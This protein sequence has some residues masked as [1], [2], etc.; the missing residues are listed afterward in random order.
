MTLPP[1]IGA[2][3]EFE[4]QLSQFPVRTYGPGQHLFFEDLATMLWALVSHHYLVSNF[5][6]VNLVG[7]R[8]E[9]H[10]RNL[11]A[12]ISNMTYRVELEADCTGNAVTFLT[13][14]VIVSIALGH[15]PQY[16]RIWDVPR[17]TVGNG[18]AIRSSVFPPLLRRLVG[19]SFVSFFEVAKGIANSKYGPNPYAWPDAL[20]FARIIRNSVAHGF[21][22]H[23][24]N[25]NA[26]PVTWKKWTYGPNDNGT[27]S[28]LA[29]GALN[30]GDIIILMEE[31]QDKL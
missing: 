27:P 13:Q 25:L 16:I 6:N 5:D 9:P 12:H 7:G 30:I 4:R 17:G 23:F 24:D 26:M 20:N 19:A 22:L 3:E 1:F 11:A 15:W 29:P 10:W 28:L 21:E 18:I 31:M 14:E 8:P 2:L